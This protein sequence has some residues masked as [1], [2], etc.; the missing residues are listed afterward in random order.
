MGWLDRRRHRKLDRSIPAA[1][2]SPEENEENAS[3]FSG[4]ETIESLRARVSDRP[5]DARAV[6]ELASRLRD[7]DGRSADAIAVLEESERLYESLPG[8]GLV[9]ALADVRCRKG[10]AQAAAGHG[11]SAVLTLDEALSGYDAVGAD[12]PR[13]PYVLDYAQAFLVNADILRRY[14][15]PDLAV[16]SADGAKRCSRRATVSSCRCRTSDGQRSKSISGSGR[17]AGRAAAG[18][19]GRAAGRRT[20]AGRPVRWRLHAPGPAC[21]T[22]ADSA[23]EADA[24][25]DAGTTTVAST[26]INTD[27]SLRVS[28]PATPPRTTRLHDRSSPPVPQQ[29]HHRRRAFYA[30]AIVTARGTGCRRRSGSGRGRRSSARPGPWGLVSGRPASPSLRSGP[31]PSGRGRR[32]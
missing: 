2:I 10:Q 3:G 4:Q 17:R 24:G 6:R 26:A 18:G 31:A 21:R 20:R 9:A 7:T 23:V 16:A 32:S 22:A 25:R 13:S 30:I 1:R 12:L 11:A 5:H 29:D 14:G 28:E 8:E 19:D 27:T 15:E